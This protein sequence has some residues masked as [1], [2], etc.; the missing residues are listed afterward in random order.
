M[1]KLDTIGVQFKHMSDE[2]VDIH[3]DTPKEHIIIM[4]KEGPISIDLKDLIKELK[5]YNLEEL[6]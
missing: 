2:F 5:I 4:T 3:I 6:K 1:L